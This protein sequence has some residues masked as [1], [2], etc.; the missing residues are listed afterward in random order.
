[1]INRL[2]NMEISPVS[3]KEKPIENNGIYTTED[4]VRAFISG[5]GET[6]KLRFKKM[7][8]NGIECGLSVADNYGIDYEDFIKEVKKQMEVV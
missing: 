2:I 8:E 7:L 1:M 5:M 3:L 4:Y 6:Q